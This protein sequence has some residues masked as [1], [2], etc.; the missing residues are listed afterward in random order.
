VTNKEKT[1]LNNLVFYVATRLGL[2]GVDVSGLFEIEGLFTG[3]T[4]IGLGLSLIL[5]IVLAVT[6]ALGKMPL[7]G[8]ILEKLKRS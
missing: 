6:I 7:V 4:Q 5:V 2:I 8:G 3:F 1:Q